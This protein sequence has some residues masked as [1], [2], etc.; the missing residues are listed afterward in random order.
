MFNVTQSEFVTIIKSDLRSRK[1]AILALW[2]INFF[3]ETEEKSN[4]SV[5]S[6]TLSIPQLEIF[7][8]SSSGSIRWCPRNDHDSRGTP[9]SRRHLF[10]DRFAT[11]GPAS[12]PM[13][14]ATQP[15]PRGPSHRPQGQPFSD[16]DAEG[17][18][19]PLR[20]QHPA[21]Q[22]PQ[23]GGFGNFDGFEF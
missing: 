1:D 17:L 14:A 23:K 13:P 7:L 21:G 20:R 16:H 11:D 19:P 12:V 8:L 3:S 5:T 15:G 6:T 9:R 2:S 4:S 22:V 18:R 10:G